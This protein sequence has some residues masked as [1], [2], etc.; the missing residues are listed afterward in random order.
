M[1]L[2]LF[3]SRWL[4]GRTEID[5]VGGV[6][7]A[8][9]DWT[10]NWINRLCTPAHA[11]NRMKLSTTVLYPHIHARSFFHPRRIPFL[12]LILSLSLSLFVSLVFLFLLQSQGLFP[13]VI[14]IIRGQY[15]HSL[16]AKNKTL[17]FLLKK[18]LF[19]K[20]SPLSIWIFRYI[21][22]RFTTFTISLLS[23]F[24]SRP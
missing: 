22:K 16:N 24:S 12:P 4:E 2:G 8:G 6:V 3:S 20:I 15:K 17:I 18:T 23:I 13:S 21:Y 10:A 1:Q 14:C 5:Q 9:A 19:K 11:L 7:F